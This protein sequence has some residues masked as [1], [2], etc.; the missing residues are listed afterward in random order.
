MKTSINY[1]SYT[2]TT[3][4]AI[5]KEDDKLDLQFDLFIKALDKYE[6]LKPFIESQSESSV[7]FRI[8]EESAAVHMTIN[9]LCMLIYNE[10]V[11]NDGKHCKKCEYKGYC[12]TIGGIRNGL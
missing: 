6:E 4:Y 1:S 5:G 7:M 3:Y 9:R 10:C 8:P 11:Y 12:D 2:G